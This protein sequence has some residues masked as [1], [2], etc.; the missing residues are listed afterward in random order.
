MMPVVALKKYSTEFP[1]T[2]LS[3]SGITSDG[4]LKEALV[5]GMWNSQLS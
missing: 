3:L 4:N 5:V 2:V 1:N